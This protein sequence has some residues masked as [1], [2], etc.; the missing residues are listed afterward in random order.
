MDVFLNSSRVRGFV[1][2]TLSLRLPQK[3]DLQGVKSEECKGQR[4][5]LMTQSSTVSRRVLKRAWNLAVKDNRP[6]LW[7]IPLL[8]VVKNFDVLQRFDSM[9][10]CRYTANQRVFLEQ[11]HVVGMKVATLYCAAKGF[12]KITCPSTCTNIAPILRQGVIRYGCIHK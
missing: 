3:R 1:L 7:I 10:Q 8:L 2:Y 5:R 12:C 11:L 6:S 9:R 4:P